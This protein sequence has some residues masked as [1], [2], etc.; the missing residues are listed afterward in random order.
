M[1]LNIWTEFEAQTKIKSEVTYDTG[2]FV[3][4]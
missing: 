4:N 3:E 1:Y 2:K